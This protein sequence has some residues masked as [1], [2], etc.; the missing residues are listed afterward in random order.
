MHKQAKKGL[1]FI[2]STTK[3]LR[4]HEDPKNTTLF[5]FIENVDGKILD[6]SI[7]A[8]EQLNIY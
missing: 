1:Q 4:S 5:D 2:L 8:C 3:Q 7:L 6:D